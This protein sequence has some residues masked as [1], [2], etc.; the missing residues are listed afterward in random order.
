M[1]VVIGIIATL[2]A[3]IAVGAAG[4]M[5]KGRIARVQTEL[6][7]LE[8]AIESYKSK[9]G[10]YPPD[11]TNNSYQNP[12]F[13]ELTGTI[14]T[15]SNS[16][17]YFA[18]PVGHD[19]LAASTVATL[20]N[21]GGFINSSADSNEVQNFFGSRPLRSGETYLAVTSNVGGVV[22]PVFVTLGVPVQG[23]VQLRSPT[24]G[25]IINPWHYNSSN[26]TNN[27]GSY[28]LWM[29]IISQG[30]TNR[31]SNWSKDPQIVY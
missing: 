21:M 8:T 23:P 16:L 30:K 26:P 9:K 10:F 7:G 24:L 5:H 1:L 12:L 28:D 13:Y 4:V 29:D 20:F 18:S 27:A 15:N 14:P 17:P 22:S 19:M 25:G 11:N 31:I 6:K 2:A 3:L